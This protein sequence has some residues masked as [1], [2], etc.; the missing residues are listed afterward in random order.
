MRL[1]NRW[2]QSVRTVL[3]VHCVKNHSVYM[4][5][6][7]SDSNKILQNS[8]PVVFMLMLLVSVTVELALSVLTQQLTTTYISFLVYQ[9]M[10]FSWVTFNRNHA[11]DQYCLQRT[12]DITMTWVARIQCRNSEMNC[13]LADVNKNIVPY[14][15]SEHTHTTWDLLWMTG[16]LFSYLISLCIIK[17]VSYTHLTL[18]T[19]REV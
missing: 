7:F 8:I 2:C 11:L 4:L 3:C 1:N 17:P 16:E 14:S 19:N 15:H 6:T 9:Q 10:H 12:I 5:S 18:P 13:L